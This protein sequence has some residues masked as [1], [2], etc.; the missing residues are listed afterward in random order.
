MM[1]AEQQTQNRSDSRIIFVV[2]IALLLTTICCAAQLGI[3]VVPGWLEI[4]VN[5][6]ATADYSVWPY[7][8]FQQVDSELGTRIAIENGAPTLP[9]EIADN[10]TETNTP[11]DTATFTPTPSSTPTLTAT[12]VPAVVNP[13]ATITDT[14][15][16][17]AATQTLTATVSSVTAVVTPT[18]TSVAAP[19][20]QFVTDKVSGTAPLTVNFFDR[21]SGAITSYIWNFGDG[22]SLVSTQNPSYTF[23]NPGTY[24]VVLI[25]TG[26]GGSSSS[27]LT[28]TVESNVT[29][30]P[31]SASNVDLEL[32]GTTSSSSPLENDTVTMTLNLKNNS[33]RQGTNIRINLTLSNGLTFM[34]AAAAQ[35]TYSG[36]VWNVGSLA[37]NASTSLAL[38]VRVNAGTGGAVLVNSAAVSALTQTDSN[39]SNNA[40]TMNLSIA[41]Q[42]ADLGVAVNINT[43]A[44]SEGGVV[45]YTVQ[46]TNDGPITATNIVVSDQLPSAV[47]YVSQ[48]ASAGTYNPSTGA[49]TVASLASRANATLSLWAVVNAGTAGTPVTNTASISSATQIDPNTG[50]NSASV[51]FTSVPATSQAELGLS[52]SVNNP[53]PYPAD[54]IWYS[55]T[56]NN[57]GPNPATGVQISAPLPSQVTYVTSSGVGTYD[58][59]SGA[60]NI[61]NIGIGGSVTLNIQVSVNSG[62][63]GLSANSSAAI[64]ASNQP[65]LNPSNNT[66]NLTVNVGSRGV[67]TNMAVDDANPVVGQTI[68]YTFNIRNLMTIPATGVVAED[69]LPSDLT[70]VSASGPGTYNAS[71]GRWNIGT[72][73]PGALVSL[74]IRASVDP[75]AAGK[76]ITNTGRVIA[77]DQPDSDTSNNT[78]SRNISVFVVDLVLAKSVNNSFPSEGAPIIYTVGLDNNTSF[79]AT[80]IQVTDVLPSG[81]TFVS[82]SATQ[83]AYDSGS[84]I[85]DIGTVGAGMTVRLTINARVDVGTLGMTITNTADISAGD[86]GD[87]LPANNT[88][89]AD[90]TVT[91]ADLAVSKRVADSTRNVGQTTTY[92]VTVTNNMSVPATGVQIT[93]LLPSGVDFVS[94]NPQQGTYDNVSGIWNIGSITAN[95]LVELRI[96]VRVNVSASG[97]TVTNSATIAAA[98]QTDNNSTNNTGS[99]SF[100][101]PRFDADISLTKTVN[102]AT[103]NEGQLITYTV[104]ARNNGPSTATG[105]RLTD[106][107]PS[108]LTLQSANVTRG[109]YNT[110]TGLWNMSSLNNGDTAQLTITATVNASTSGSTITN[111]AAVTALDQPDLVSGNNSASVDIVVQ[112]TDLSVTKTVNT[113]TPAEGDTVTFSVTIANNGPGAVSN[114]EITD[115]LPFGLTFVNASAT[116]G[117]YDNSTG[118]WQVGALANG[119]NAV[120]TINATVNTGT[121][122]G[123]ITNTASIS[124]F[125][126]P[127]L[128][129]SNN[130][131]NASINVQLAGLDIQTSKTVDNQLPNEGDTITYTVSLFNNGSIAATNVVATDLLP[132]SLTFV[133]ASPSQGTYNNNSGIWTVGTV[134]A[135]DTE[136]LIISARVNSGTAGSDILNTATLTGLDQ[137]DNNSGNNSASVTIRVVVQNLELTSLC[138]PEPSV[139]RVWRVRNYNQNDI[140]FDWEVYGP[141]LTGSETAPAASGAT[142]GE[143]VFTTPTVA[144][145]M[146]VVIRVGGVIHDT[147]GGNSTPCSIDLALSQ[148]VDNATPS[149]NDIINYTITVSNPSSSNASG[150]QVSIAFPVELTFISANTA[151]GS[152][153]GGVWDI[154]SIGSSGT[155]TLTI[156]ARVNPGTAGQGINFRSSIV[157]ANQPDP[158]SSNNT[159]E[160]IITVQSATARTANLGLTIVVTNTSPVE[161]EEIQYVLTY[162]NSGP[163]T[164][165]QVVVL[166]PL[167]SGVTYLSHMGGNFDSATG[168]WALG[169]IIN[170][171]N[172]NLTINVR[173]NNGTVGQSFD[174]TATISAASNDPDTSNN[175]QTASFTVR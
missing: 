120:L 171:Q 77:L 29:N 90:I 122:G 149:E 24:I 98:D 132:S 49:W 45:Q 150:V 89:S 75:A 31:T 73:D 143:I 50:N 40:A 8:V 84:G 137:T 165:S 14:P 116:Q 47:T 104:T 140:Q 99:A 18:S 161:G 175:S 106:V 9:P 157:A 53:S 12:A 86:Q 16:N 154:G 34:S 126:V 108:G 51:S 139:Y 74:T 25:V 23:N 52:L 56:V 105:L 92:V 131:A 100:T 146:T 6:A 121:A 33:S 35:G 107:L 155:A 97:T 39:T 96:V 166:S 17:S 113:S 103:P 5:P 71:T 172:G 114:V 41:G 67:R 13:T 32:S 169:D 27:S 138:S 101:V 54:L 147:K 128:N 80:G 61:G 111:T 46:L 142:P 7:S 173:V 117:T 85:W 63:E 2:L 135:G 170:G 118:V 153:S 94:A 102:N 93:D 124:L 156:S 66:A 141:G 36:G 133:S 167:P 162:S 22:S 15:Q 115:T 82:A 145:P 112:G 19:V 174:T 60:W 127:D 26:P 55:L 158:T 65:D 123:T 119:G 44:P 168:Q 4:G 110:T 64:I 69:V 134:N 136:S 57:S 11:Q 152:Y 43:N 59:A 83:G 62:T 10:P 28:I 78:A 163:D 79:D 68:T 37:G 72:I 58:A 88:A 38:I 3:G 76:T 21:S 164:A 91:T 159:A 87:P 148:N 1:N 129:G 109:S 48:S 144:N 130:S 42:G 125:V 151:Q 81:V 30:T 20:A 70:F 95:S 160:S